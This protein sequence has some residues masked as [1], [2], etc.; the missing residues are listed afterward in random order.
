MNFSRQIGA[1]RSVMRALFHYGQCY[2]QHLKRCYMSS[3]VAASQNVKP[4]ALVRST[5]F[6]ELQLVEAAGVLHVQILHATMMRNMMTLSSLNFSMVSF[7]SLKL[8]SNLVVM[9][10]M[11]Q[12]VDYIINQNV[13]FDNLNNDLKSCNRQV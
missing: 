11:S 1:G 9:K 10:Q 4:G 5:T 6:T 13:L 3:G 7:I 2:L 12:Q 8:Y